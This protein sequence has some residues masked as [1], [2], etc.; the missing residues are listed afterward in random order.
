MSKRA[1]KI[2]LKELKKDQLEEQIIDLYE[3]FGEVKTYY[4][5]IFNPKEDKLIN[6]AKTKI[7]KEYFPTT[8]K[9]PKARR[10][11]A[12]KYIKHFLQIGMEERLLADLMLFN[13]ET[14]QRFNAK[15]PQ[16][17]EAFF[18]S[19]ANSFVQALNFV[20]YHG[21]Q[22]EF[23]GRINTLVIESKNQDWYNWDFLLEKVE[24]FGG[25]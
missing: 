6:E 13:L 1:L 12:Q 16:K 7:E 20:H 23:Q 18:K 8:R 21:L 14:A 24:E 25:L 3:R 10:G 19:M 5:F 2:Y 11:T 17:T 4:D 22:N 9:R 15:R